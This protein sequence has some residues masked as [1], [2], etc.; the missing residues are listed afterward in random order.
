MRER[1]RRMRRLRRGL[2]LAATALLVAGG[3]AGD[4]GAISP[5]ESGFFSTVAVDEAPAVTTSS[6][7][8]LWPSCWSNDGN[9]YAANGDGTGF[10]S[11]SDDIVVNRIGGDPSP[12]TLSG[13]EL[14]HGSQ[15]GQIWADPAF[16]TRKPTG[17]LC[18]G[19]TLYIAVQDLNKNFNDAP[20]A[21]IAKSTDHGATWT[22]NRSAPMFSNGVATTIF[23]LDYGQDGASNPTPGYVYAYA[24]DHN[25]R[26][27]YSGSVP[28]PV[29]LYLAR[30]PVSSIQDAS[31]W[32]WS[33]GPGTWSAPGA[34][35]QRVAVLHDDR[36]I[37]QNLYSSNVHNLTVL[38]QGGVVYDAP[39]SRYIYTSWSEYT[40]EFYEAPNP[41][42]PWTHFETKDFG[43]YPWSSGKMGGYATT[44]PSKF[45]DST[46][47]NVWLQSNVCSCGG[48]GLADYSFNLRRLTLTPFAPSTASN[49]ESNTTNLAQAPGTTPIERVAHF[50]NNGYYNDGVTA[51]QS[52][53]DWND[54]SKQ[55]SWWGYT[56]PQQY[57]FDQVAFT[58]GSIFSDGGWFASGL[59]VQV[60]QN[61]QWNDVANES[62]YPSY[63]YDS[64]AGPNR[65][66]TFTFPAVSG[67]GVRVIGA[68][69]GTK[70]FTSIAE[71]AVYNA[72]PNL[73]ADPGF[74][75][76]TTSTIAAPWAGEGPDTKGIDINN[77]FAHS[78]A[79][80]AWIH[81][82][83]T[84]T[85]SWNAITQTIPVSPN[86]A[87]TLTGWIQDSSNVSAGYFGLRDGGTSTVLAE[88][89]FGSLPGYTQLAVTFNSGANTTVTIY[90]GY[91]APGADSWLRLDD[92]DLVA[93]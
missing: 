22:W 92:F 58:S 91:W 61:F 55:A 17:M 33:T 72:H 14:A 39:L 68:P 77:G 70:T 86:T 44:I 90:A 35:S 67:D 31:S 82:A 19:G 66:Y 79:N 2:L 93:G 29:D 15:V 3:G 5:P 38:S 69:G 42:G 54:E 21:T 60:R 89:K 88:T 6:N 30:I 65:T 49:A 75:A 26:T 53:D 47:R 28:N 34:I 57:T 4:A 20:N 16:Y 59:H 8:D 50:G 12:N 76:Q 71:L 87:Y 27:S 40:F 36:V 56:W 24:L 73:V 51:N 84:A 1:D 43:G 45:I 46:G 18:V 25:W 23:F 7:G 10:G 63:P 37:Y 64:T 78:G 81:P 41:W 74:E 13:A 9:L 83:N 11:V 52:E 62:I 85:T 80:N 48:A 32:Q